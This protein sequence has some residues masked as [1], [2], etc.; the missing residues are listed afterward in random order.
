MECLRLGHLRFAARALYS[1]GIH[2]RCLHFAILEAEYSHA[3]TGVRLTVAYQ[4][5]VFRAYLGLI[6]HVESLFLVA[7]LSSSIITGAAICGLRISGRLKQR[8]FKL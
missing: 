4:C 5:T 3:A 2:R 6:S 7:C 1:L 8:V